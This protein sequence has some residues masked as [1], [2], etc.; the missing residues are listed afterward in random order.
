MIDPP[1]S[2]G[3]HAQLRT[4]DEALTAAA[5]EMARVNAELRSRPRRTTHGQ[6]EAQRH[7]VTAQPL[8]VRSASHVHRTEDAPRGYSCCHGQH[9]A[10]L[11]QGNSKQCRTETGRLPV[12]RRQ[13]FD[14]LTPL[15]ADSLHPHGVA[16]VNPAHRPWQGAGLQ[17]KA[18]AWPPPPPRTA[19]CGASDLTDQHP[20]LIPAASDHNNCWS[21]SENGSWETA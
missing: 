19:P 1:W 15:P 8:P 7:T 13:L 11:Q 2:A 20:E 18:T 12:P 14:A 17:G 16:R 4:R 6:S 5:A 3:L 10:A 21:D 9:G